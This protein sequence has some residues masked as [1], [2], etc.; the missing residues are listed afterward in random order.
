VGE[1]VLLTLCAKAKT[2]NITGAN[3][4]EIRRVLEA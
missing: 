3:L 1:V 4:K 2:D